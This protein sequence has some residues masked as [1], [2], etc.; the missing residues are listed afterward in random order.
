MLNCIRSIFQQ[1][2]RRIPT[3]L[4]LDLIPAFLPQP[5]QPTASP[6]SLLLA[7]VS[8]GLVQFQKVAPRL[9]IG[10]EICAQDRPTLRGNRITAVVSVWHAIEPLASTEIYRPRFRRQKYIDREGRLFNF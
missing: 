5:N 6:T 10:N 1:F 7:Q 2:G 3:L 8:T 4:S 9:F